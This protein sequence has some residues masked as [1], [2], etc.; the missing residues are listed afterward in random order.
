MAS[1]FRGVEL[2]H[3]KEIKGDPENQQEHSYGIH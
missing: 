1:G 3:F 2:W